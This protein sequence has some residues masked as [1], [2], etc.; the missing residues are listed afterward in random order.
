ML[1][2]KSKRLKRLSLYIVTLFSMI[3]F[4]SPIVVYADFD[5]SASLIA[6]PETTDTAPEPLVPTMNVLDYSGDLN[7]RG[8][9]SVY[10]YQTQDS[11]NTNGSTTTQPIGGNRD[12]SS[13]AQHNA[14]E[15]NKRRTAEQA[16]AEELRFFNALV[17]DLKGISSLGLDDNQMRIWTQVLLDEVVTMHAEGLN[18][19]AIA[20]ILGN[21]YCE[22]GCFPHAI[23]GMGF[24]ESLNAYSVVTDNTGNIFVATK[25]RGQSRTKDDLNLTTVDYSVDSTQSID[26]KAFGLIQYT[27]GTSVENLDISK[28]DGLRRS[29][30][31]W[32]CYG[33]QPY[34]G[35]SNMA[36]TYRFTNNTIIRAYDTT[37]EYLRSYFGSFPT[38]PNTEIFETHLS[39]LIGEENFEALK[40]YTLVRNTISESNFTVMDPIM[41]SYYTIGETRMG[42]PDVIEEMEACAT[43]GDAVF[44]YCFKVERPGLTEE[45]QIQA[46]KERQEKLESGAYANQF[47]MILYVISKVSG[48]PELA[49]RC[50]SHMGG[51]STYVTGDGVYGTDD[52]IIQ[53]AA[54][55]VAGYR[56]SISPTQWRRLTKMADVE[57]DGTWLS[58]AT[59]TNLRR[60]DILGLE[61]WETNV[62]ADSFETRISRGG[63]TIVLIVGI[64]IT[65]WGVLFYLAFWVDRLNTIIFLNLVGILTIF[66][67]RVSDAEDNAT[68]SLMD[69]EKK[70]RVKTINHRDA[71]TISIS[72][73]AFGVLFIS[74]L[75]FKILFALLTWLSTKFM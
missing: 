59:R 43:P 7:D 28:F 23:Y 3:F 25:L 27:D 49:T 37:N 14:M 74:G 47:K 67:L 20:G 75:M 66:H 16:I 2:G 71:I 1:L 6:P 52:S 60:E 69:S 36:V 51:P 64:L 8:Y 39:D 29:R 24:H 19:T 32:F 11:S 40:D 33:T 5:T 42:T 13:E 55:C 12:Y 73:I 62:Q 68:Y 10:D 53:A 34:F 4:C 18:D 22:S 45:A 21:A 26:N 35:S 61:G 30:Y 65:I 54:S 58:Q 46:A 72:A 56:N 31:I 17:G 70:S 9:G 48:N 50:G 44:I 41:A 15:E 38:K 57:V 63:R